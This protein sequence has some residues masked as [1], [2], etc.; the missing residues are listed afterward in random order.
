MTREELNQYADLRKELEETKQRIKDTEKQILRLEQMGTVKDTVKGGMGG[1]Q[2]F[3]IEGVPLGIYSKKK[4]ILTARKEML[5]EQ[6]IKYE[7]MTNDIMEFIKNIPDSHTRRVFTLRFVDG[8]R[9]QDVAE[10]IGGGNTESGVKKIF[11]RYMK[12]CHTCH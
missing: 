7:Q 10:K 11:E 6:S 4:A 9:W 8:L 12:C 5:R 1:I 2:H 3:V